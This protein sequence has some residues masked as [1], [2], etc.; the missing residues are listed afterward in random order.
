MLQRLG[1]EVLET[2]R[3]L[4]VLG[5]LHELKKEVEEMGARLLLREL[6]DVHRRVKGAPLCVDHMS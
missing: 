5:A 3:T 1:P 2:Q 4:R 6:P